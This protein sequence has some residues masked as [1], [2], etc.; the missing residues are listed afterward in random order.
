MSA[1]TKAEA[2]ETRIHEADETAGSR[3]DA[4]APLD[5][6][7]AD[8]TSSPLRRFIPGMS[9]VRFTAALARRPQ[10][11]RR[12]RPGPDRR[13]GQ[14]RGR[15]LRGRA[16]REG[17][18]LLRGGLGQEPGAAAHPAELPRDAARPRAGWSRTPSSAGATASGWASSSTTS[19]R[20]PRPATTR[21]ST[22]RCSSAS[23]TPAAATSSR[24]ADASSATSPRAPRVPSMVEPDAFEVGT[25]IAVTPGAVVLRTDVF[26][27]IQYTPQTPKVREVPLLIV[28]PTI[29]K[30]YVID[31]A[32]QRSLVE[33]LV[34]QR[35]AGLLHLLAQPGRPARRLGPG[36][37]RPGDHR[38]DGRPP[39]R[40]RAR[41][42]SP[43]SASA[44]AACSP[45]WCWPT[46][47][48]PATSTGSRRSASP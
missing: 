41:T 9:G 4:A 44:R 21:S 40:S 1:A 22:R 7:L 3:D 43:C 18:P 6:L 23:S 32:E 5:L 29:N 16:A 47:P 36:H 24:A 34:A 14:D 45:R 26:E 12:S 35:P 17:P 37:L 33:H 31:L 13:A 19:S 2:A 30:Y 48:P 8:A 39:R 42:R 28:P 10:R 20:P 38:G 11:G 27:L 15:P 25:D 46:S